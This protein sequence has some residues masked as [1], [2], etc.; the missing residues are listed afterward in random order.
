MCLTVQPVSRTFRYNWAGDQIVSPLVPAAR[1]VPGT[2]QTSLDIDVREFL[3]IE[4]S[5]EVRRFFLS[6]ILDH[7]SATEQMRFFVGHKGNFDFRM[8]AVIEAFGSLAYKPV[9]G[10]SREEWLFPAET[11]AAGGGDCED[12]S[13]L[14]VALLEEGGISRACL[15]LAFG[16][17]AEISPT[18][19][20]T[21]HDHAWVVYQTEGGS[22]LILDPVERVEQRSRRSRTKE[23]TFEQDTGKPSMSS[24]YLTRYEYR[25]EFVLNRD[26]LWRV[27]GPRGPRSPRSLDTYLAA[28]RT[29]ET[30]DPSFGLGVHN[31]LFD[32]AMPELSWI[33]RFRVKTA[34]LALDA[35]VLTYDPRDHCDFGYINESWKGIVQRLATGD[36]EDLGRA[37]HTVADFYAHSLYAHVVRASGGRLPLYDPNAPPDPGTRQ[38][39]VFDRTRFP[40]DASA[41]SLSPSQAIRHW[42]GRLISGQWW[43][44]YTTYPDELQTPAE[45][46]PRRSLPDHDV[47]AVDEP[48]SSDNPKHLYPTRAAYAAQY[49]LRYDA[50]QRH[51]RQLFLGWAKMHR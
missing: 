23:P 26:H 30:F 27:N 12:L 50:A 21:A 10:R 7:R 11:L 6:R 48:P 22:W 46:G 51:V 25:P 37:C 2:R 36:V 5:A 28:R 39:E 43:R 40:I 44:R 41:A 16:K 33:D 32:K 19:G 18:G 17:L 8:T 35:N 31:S 20:E 45:L 29:W 15:R 49:G 38:D 42:R 9:K 3:A 24:A 47:I 14:L 4:H 34:S 13:F 1:R